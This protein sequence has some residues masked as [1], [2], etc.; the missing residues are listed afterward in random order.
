MN[1]VKHDERDEVSD[2]ETQ[3]WLGNLPGDITRADILKA[4]R[5]YGQPRER[6]REREREKRESEKRLSKIK[7]QK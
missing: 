1:T 4:T 7:I 2:R 6:E 3:V 5:C